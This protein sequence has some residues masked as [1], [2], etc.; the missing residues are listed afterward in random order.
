LQI[1]SQPALSSFYSAFSPLK[2]LGALSDTSPLRI[3]ISA[4]IY[5][6]KNIFHPAKEILM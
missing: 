3:N 6:F 2:L 4:S 1:K 5:F